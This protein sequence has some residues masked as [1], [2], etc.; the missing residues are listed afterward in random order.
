M[1]SYNVSELY[2]AD[3]RKESYYEKNFLSISL[4]DGTFHQGYPI[5]NTQGG[6]KTQFQHL[7]DVFQLTKLSQF[8]N[9]KC[10]AMQSQ[11]D[12]LFLFN[13]SNQK[14]FSI[15]AK[16]FPQNY[17]DILEQYSHI[18]SD[19]QY[20]ESFD[21]VLLSSLKLLTKPSELKTSLEHILESKKIQSQLHQ[22]LP[23][24]NP[25]KSTKI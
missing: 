12:I 7:C 24:K 10:I 16:F 22:E 6:Y 11:N 5:C 2:I 1:L 15:Q 17:S 3:I 25:Y 8:I 13:P 23:Q 20:L 18:D 19:I 21:A 14:F 4:S 9:R